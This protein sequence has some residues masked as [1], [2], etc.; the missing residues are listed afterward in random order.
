MKE[1]QE[2]Y[3]NIRKVGSK[4]SVDGKVEATNI[5]DI[6]DLIMILLTNAV[7]LALRFTNTDRSVKPMT[8]ALVSQLKD[9]IKV[10]T[11]E[12]RDEIKTSRAGAQETPTDAI[13]KE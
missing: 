6:L 12:V 13:E 4:W 8:K 3:F 11:Q 9:I 7:R 1:E 2:V 10:E 5:K